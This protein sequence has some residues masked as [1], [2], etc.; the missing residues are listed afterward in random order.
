[1]LTMI[2]IRHKQKDEIDFRNELLQDQYDIEQVEVKKEEDKP[3]LTAQVLGDLQMLLAVFLILLLTVVVITLK[4]KL[5]R[6]SQSQVCCPD[7]LL[8]PRRGGRIDD[9]Q[10]NRS[11]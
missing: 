11:K 8:I 2:E 4:V 6:E 9:L 10:T 5:D 7:F 1:M 3:L